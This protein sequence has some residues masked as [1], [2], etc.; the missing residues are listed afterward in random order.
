M[1]AGRSGFAADTRYAIHAPKHETFDLRGRT[2][3]DPKGIVRAVDDYTVQPWGLY[4][5]RPTPGFRRAA[6]ESRGS[7]LQIAGRTSDPDRAL[8]NL[9]ERDRMFTERLRTEAGRLALPV[10]EVDTLMTE[11]ELAER[12]AEGFALYSRP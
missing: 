7:L 9:L 3:T 10:I 11:E 1:S 6:F 2:N 5:A 12:V 4:V 8:R